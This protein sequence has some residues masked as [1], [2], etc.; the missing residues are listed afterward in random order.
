MVGEVVITILV[1]VVGVPLILWRL[2]TTIPRLGLWMAAR[3]EPFAPRV[4]SLFIEESRDDEQEG[5]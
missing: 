3:I 4:A 1:L 2:G 5:T